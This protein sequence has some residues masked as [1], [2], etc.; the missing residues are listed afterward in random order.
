ME[1]VLARVSQYHAS[2]FSRMSRISGHSLVAREGGPHRSRSKCASFQ[3]RMILETSGLQ[4]AISDVGSTPGRHS[5][6]SRAQGARTKPNAAALV[7]A[8]RVSASRLVP[9]LL[10]ASA[11]SSCPC[12]CSARKLQSVRALPTSGSPS[13]SHGELRGEGPGRPARRLGGARVR[14]DPGVSSTSSF[15]WGYRPNVG[16]IPRL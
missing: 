3:G 5:N 11:A 1:K 14:L 13:G 9:G 15:S 16:K 2:A 6:P 8:A 4:K 12:P 10:P 7:P